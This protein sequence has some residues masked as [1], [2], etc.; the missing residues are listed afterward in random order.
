MTSFDEYGTIDLKVKTIVFKPKRYPLKYKYSA[1]GLKKDYVDV[2]MDQLIRL[3]ETKRRVYYYTN[4]RPLLVFSFP[5][6]KLEYLIKEIEN[7]LKIS[8]SYS[9]T[10]NPR[11]MHFIKNYFPELIYI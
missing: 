7:N 1:F 5:K 4:S 11:V 6:S 3:H 9:F 8:S 10:H 2:S